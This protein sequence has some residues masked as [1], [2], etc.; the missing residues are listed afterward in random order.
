YVGF[1]FDNYDATGAFITTEGGTTPTN[2]TPVDSSG[3]FMSM[4]PNG[5]TG[6]FTSGTDMITQL[7]AST[8]ARECFALQELRYAVQR[9]E[10]A[11][12]ACSAQQ[13]FQSGGFNVQSLL[14]AIVR[15]DSFRNRSPVNAG[16]ACQ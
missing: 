16:A 15:T 8:Q 7:A 4:N 9:S 5:L 10:Q 11:G 6:S 1:A 12:D 14:L 13:A 2:G 3:M